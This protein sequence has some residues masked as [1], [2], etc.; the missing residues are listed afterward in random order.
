M[1]K[2]V[3]FFITLFPSFVDI[4]VLVQKAAVAIARS[5]PQHG[6]AGLVVFAKSVKKLSDFYVRTLGLKVLDGCDPEGHILQF[7]Q[8]LWALRA[9]FTSAIA[10]FKSRYSSHEKVQILS[11][12]ARCSLALSNFPIWT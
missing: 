7:K 6:Q 2:I 11:R 3:S 5:I 4:A 1:D 9:Y 8:K 12:L 10:F